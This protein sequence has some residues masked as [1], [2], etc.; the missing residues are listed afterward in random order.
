MQNQEYVLAALD[1]D[2]TLLNSRHEISDYTRR[3]L[4]RAGAAGYQ[5]A[6]ATGRCVSE[7]VKP[8]HGL[9]AVR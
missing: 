7:L 4:S 6:L 3:A 2:G 5:I 9:D 1:M 8:L